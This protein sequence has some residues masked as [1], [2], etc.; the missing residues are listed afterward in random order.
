MVPIYG[1]EHDRLGHRI[2]EGQFPGRRIVGINVNELYTYGGIIHCVTQQ[3]L[4]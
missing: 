1:D 3:H 2:I 4:E